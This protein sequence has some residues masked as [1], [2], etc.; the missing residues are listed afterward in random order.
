MN[1]LGLDIVTLSLII[2][3]TGT[4]IHQLKTNYGK[5]LPKI[6]NGIMLTVGTSFVATHTALSQIIIIDPF[7][8]T[9]LIMSLVGFTVPGAALGQ[10]MFTKVK[11]K[12]QQKP[13]EELQRLIPTKKGRF[14]SVP[15]LSPTDSWYQNNFKKSQNGNSIPYGQLYLWIK[16]KD[17]RSYVTVI[18]KDANG[19]ALQIDQSHEYDED[20]NVE[21]T[22]LELIKPDGTP[23]PKG[24]YHLQTRGDRGTGD[25]QG[26]KNDIFEIV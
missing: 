1:I 2:A 22:R 10:K 20:N 7:Q 23:F 11:Q 12:V 25:S 5:P 26:I 14:L 19:I 15:K 6:I 8:Q 4:V 24:I 17:V 21:T 3:V 13:R 9:L 16:V 18:L